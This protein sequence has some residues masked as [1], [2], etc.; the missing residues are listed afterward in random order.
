MEG[1]RAVLHLP[2]CIEAVR[3]SG[4]SFWGQEALAGALKNDIFIVFCFCFNKIISVGSNSAQFLLS[5]NF[6]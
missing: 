1:G 5:F 4:W 2:A 6:F 3:D